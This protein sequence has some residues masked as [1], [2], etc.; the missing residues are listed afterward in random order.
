MLFTDIMFFPSPWWSLQYQAIFLTTSFLRLEARAI[1]KLGDLEDISI[2]KLYEYL[3]RDITRAPR[4]PGA[5]NDDPSQMDRPLRPI[6]CEL[7]SPDVNWE[8]SWRR[9]R[10]RGLSPELSSFILKVLWTITPTRE[11]IHQ[12]LPNLYNSPDCPLC[13]D[14]RTRVPESLAHALGTCEGNQGLIDRLLDQLRLHQQEVTLQQ[15]LTLDFHIDLSIELPV[16]WLIIST[17]YSVWKPGGEGRVKL[18]RKRA[19][20]ES[21]C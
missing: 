18:A 14:D 21:N 20:L 3:V 15:V 11:Q 17:L 10:L 5:E 8:R 6:R 19:E 4:A 9:A 13:G 12:I 7:K 16:I 1:A 2:G